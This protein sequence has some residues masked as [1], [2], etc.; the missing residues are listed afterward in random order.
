MSLR[1]LPVDILLDRRGLVTLWGLIEDMREVDCEFS[2]VGNEV[3]LLLLLCTTE[4][5]N[6][7]PEINALATLHERRA[8][9]CE[10]P[11]RN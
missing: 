4:C 2:G 8:R 3:G 7:E 10:E 5:G 6:G 1:P 9:C 11:A